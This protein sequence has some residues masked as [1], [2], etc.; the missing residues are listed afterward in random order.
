MLELC[1]LSII[2]GYRHF[3]YGGKVGVAEAL[4]ANLQ[5]RFPGLQVAGTYT[6]PFRPLTG[7]EESKLIRQVHESQPHILWCGISTP[8]Q[9]R[10]MAQY[11][12]TIPVPLMIGV[13]AAFDIHSGNTKDAPDW[14]KAAGMQ[15]LYR[16]LMEPRRLT[17]RYLRNNPRFI[18]LSYLQLSGIRKYTL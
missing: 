10:F 8:T 17:G 16:M 6:P 1:R 11:S 2:R 3:F 14:I 12:G 5:R 9:E 4:A 7:A 13:G 15:W 18:W